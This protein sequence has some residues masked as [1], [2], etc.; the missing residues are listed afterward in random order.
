MFADCQNLMKVSLCISITK[1][2]IPKELTRNINTDLKM[3]KPDK[4]QVK[5]IV[6]AVTKM[7]KGYSN[8]KNRKRIDEPTI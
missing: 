7:L 2:T 1:F 8:D 3:G 6:G 4:M 5:S